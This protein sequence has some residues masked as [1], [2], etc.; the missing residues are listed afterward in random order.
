MLRKRVRHQVAA[1]E[2]QAAVAVEA[3]LLLAPVQRL[4]RVVEVRNDLLRRRRPSIEEQVD[5]EIGHRLRDGD[6]PHRA[7][8]L[9]PV[10]GLSA[11]RITRTLFG[12]ERTVLVTRETLRRA[13]PNPA[14]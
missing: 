5:L 14:A 7:S 3:T 2:R 9:E 10:D 11:W 13:V 1:D 6:G 4:V 8:R 12:V